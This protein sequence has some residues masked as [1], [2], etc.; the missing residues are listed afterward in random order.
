MLWNNTAKEM[1][2]YSSFIYNEFIIY[3]E[4]KIHEKHLFATKHETEGIPTSA[5][6][7]IKTHRYNGRF[8][9]SS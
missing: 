3:N 4:F 5:I 6:L 8:V 7:L 2:R 9:F 1:V